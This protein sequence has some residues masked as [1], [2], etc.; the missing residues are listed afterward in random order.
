MFSANKNSYLQLQTSVNP[1]LVNKA[2]RRAM[3]KTQF[4]PHDETPTAQRMTSMQPSLFGPCTDITRA[5]LG[6]ERLGLRHINRDINSEDNF[7]KLRAIHSLLDHVQISENAMFLVSL[8]TTNKLIDLLPD[9]DPI[10]REKVCLIL[11]ILGNYYQARA[12]IMAKPIVINHLMFLFMRDRKEI[13]YAAARCLKT[14]A[15]S[16]AETI[17]KNEK[18]VEN[19]IKMIKHDHEGIV[20]IHLETLT[21]LAEWNP[22]KPLKANAFK[23]MLKLILYQEDRITEAAINCLVHLCKHVV[24]QKLADKY[25]LTRFLIPYVD[26][27][28]VNIIIS[29]LGLMAYT[30]VTTRAK[31]RAK[32]FIYSLSR[33][34][35]YL[36]IVHDI[37]ALQLRAMQVLINMC[38]SPDVRG[39]MKGNLV[40][41]IEEGIK[42]RTPEQWDGS[43]EP[44]KYGLDVSHNYRTRYIDGTETVKNDKGDYVDSV[45]VPNYLQ[46]VRDTKE[47][48]LKTMDLKPY[49]SSG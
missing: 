34:L 20:L 39:F 17:I 49:G 4:D 27:D 18:V 21:H 19:L 13:R 25:D 26:S 16:E 22:E 43:T 1:T 15:R 2:V 14:L 35:V 31:W 29:A 6:F 44:R 36:C 45:T 33:R 40:K 37:P 12:R 9:Q 24:G 3:R 42:I 11:T 8:N 41:Y 32:E 48:L 46:R 23:V 30:T 38:D 10:V 7:I 28:N 47:H 5:T